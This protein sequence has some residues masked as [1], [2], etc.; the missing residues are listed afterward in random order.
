LD[1]AYVI[2]GPTSGIGYQ[3]ALN[4]AIQG[5]VV[6]VGRNA[7]KLDDVKAAI[8]RRGGRAAPVVCDMADLAAVRRAAE[9]IIALPYAIAGVL[10]NA[11][12]L[13]SEATRTAAGQDT[14][15]ATNYLGPF[16]L[17]AALAPYLPDGANLVYV[18]SAI[19]DPDRRPAR[20]MGMRGG[21][22]IS[23]EASARG[24][25]KPGG[26]RMPGIDAYATSKQC[27]LAA[28]MGFARENPRLRFNAV[29][30]G[31]T[32]GTG[33]GGVHNPFLMFLFGQIVTR[34]PPFRRYRS[35]AE[36]SARVIAQVLTDGSGQTG[37]Y[38]DE[39]GRPMRGSYLAHDPDFQHR[40][41]TETREFL[42]LGSPAAR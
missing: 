28:A 36:R 22:F 10:N 41:L 1:R 29:E 24:E 31:I 4:L 23:V 14:T 37:V 33:L 39:K 34:L 13:L 8:E 38:F 5:M 15:F 11:G 30:P 26:C 20:V 32:P 40:L 19:E 6:L 16:A 12:V 42:A 3:T 35:T 9:E 7:K 2:T 18:T 25:W 27:V 17:T 21:R